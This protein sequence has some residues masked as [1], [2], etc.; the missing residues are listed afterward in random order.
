[1][2]P[3]ERMTNLDET[4]DAYEVRITTG[5]WTAPPAGVLHHNEQWVC[6]QT[7]KDAPEVWVQWATIT[8]FAIDVLP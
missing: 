4:G 3:H 6:T 7:T 2:T 5:G 8:R 1:M